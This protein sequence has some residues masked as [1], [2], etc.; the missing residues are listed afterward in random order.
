MKSIFTLFLS[1]AM[2]AGFAQIKPAKSGT[3]YGAGAKATGAITI[4]ALEHQVEGRWI[5]QRR[6]KRHCAE[7]M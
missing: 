6:G 7:C 5:F 4:A 1:L 2:F 3:T